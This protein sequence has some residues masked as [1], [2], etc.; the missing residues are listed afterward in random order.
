MKNVKSG[1]GSACTNKRINERTAKDIPYGMTIKDHLL[2]L[3]SFRVKSFTH[4]ISKT[5]LLLFFA[6]NHPYPITLT[7]RDRGKKDKNLIIN[8]LTLALIKKT[9][10]RAFFWSWNYSSYFNV[11][12]RNNNKSRLVIRR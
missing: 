1:Q 12:K 7:I 6:S 3:T 11:A 10:L 9:I 5:L 2:Y 4:S 8:V